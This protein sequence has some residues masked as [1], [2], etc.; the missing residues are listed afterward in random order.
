MTRV[1]ARFGNILFLRIMWHG[2]DAK[3]IRPAAPDVYLQC[4]VLYRQTWLPIR[5]LHR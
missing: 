2:R 1:A 5:W 4:I 3:T